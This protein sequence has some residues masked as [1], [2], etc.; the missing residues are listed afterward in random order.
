MRH[1]VLD[2]EIGSASAKQDEGR[3]DGYCGEE[4]YHRRADAAIGL[5]TRTRFHH[6]FLAF[7]RVSGWTR[8]ELT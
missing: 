1:R 8:I 6:I 5:A 3:Q 4:I 2:G 7:A